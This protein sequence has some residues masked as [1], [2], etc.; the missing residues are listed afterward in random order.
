MNRKAEM[1]E[2][3][4]IDPIAKHIDV[5]KPPAE[6]FV[7]FVNRFSNW[8]P[9]DTHSVSAMQDQQ[10]RGIAI[11]GRVGGR[12]L[13][14]GHD[15]Q[16]IE[17]GQILV[18]EPGQRIVLSWHPG[19]G[20]DEAT[21]VEFRFSAVGANSTR[22]EMEHRNWHRLRETPQK[23]RDGYATGWDNVLDKLASA[24]AN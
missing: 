11:E 12:I 1:E 20:P 21:E 10:A 23:I 7:F 3:A 4:Q 15:G 5:G 24:L 6:A 17:W 2:A 16:D 22:I 19:H 13:E 14:T 18:Y 8:W 9:L